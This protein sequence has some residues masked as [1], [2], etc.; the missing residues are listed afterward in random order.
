MF[1]T[2]DLVK[3]LDGRLGLVKAYYS[4]YDDGTNYPL[5]VRMLDKGWR[6]EYFKLNQVELLSCSK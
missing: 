6:V 1:R 4:Q 2:Y 3:T 5:Y